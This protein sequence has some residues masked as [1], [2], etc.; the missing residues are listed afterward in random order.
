[1]RILDNKSVY[2]VQENGLVSVP[3]WAEGRLIP[4][5]VLNCKAGGIELK[6]F[7]SA[8]VSSS[9]PGDATTQWAQPVK[10][11]SK[12]KYWLLTVQFHKPREFSFIIEFTLNDHPALIDAIFQ[13]RGLYILYGFPGDKISKRTNEDMVLM[14]IPDLSQDKQWN[15]TLKEI[16]KTRFRKQGV[17]KRNI[18]SWVDKRIKEMREIL[19][20]R[21]K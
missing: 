1:M 15:L 17:D 11:F 18:N 19:H 9:E 8:H 12:T 20:Y 7:L 4:A 3:E 16:I 2:T 21:A 10:I 13:S 6:D 5:V 14:E